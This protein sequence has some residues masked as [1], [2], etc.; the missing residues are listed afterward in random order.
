MM[1]NYFLTA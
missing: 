1:G